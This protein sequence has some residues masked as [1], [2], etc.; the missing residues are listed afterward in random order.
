MNGEQCDIC[1]A[2]RYPTAFGEA[3]AEL[4]ASHL[5]GPSTTPPL[6]TAL[7]TLE[8]QTALQGAVDVAA[9]EDVWGSVV[10]M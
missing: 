10:C 1:A 8:L 5:G 2:R 7:G 6:S 4:V 3:V 9:L